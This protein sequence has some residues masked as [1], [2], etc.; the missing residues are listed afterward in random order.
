MFQRIRADRER[1]RP[2][3]ARETPNSAPFTRR[4]APGGNVGFPP[5]CVRTSPYGG[6]AERRPHLSLLTPK[7]HQRRHGNGGSEEPPPCL[8]R[9]GDARFG[10]IA[11]PPGNALATA[12]AVGPAGSVTARAE[13]VGPVHNAALAG[14]AIYHPTSVF[15]GGGKSIP[16]KQ[17]ISIVFSIHG[18]H[19]RL[20]KE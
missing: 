5:F 11:G 12:K 3:S 8:V 9:L 10:I 13:S 20:F 15:N 17:R 16:I 19:H 1:K 4:R 7:R 6:P 2:E 18:S 14:A